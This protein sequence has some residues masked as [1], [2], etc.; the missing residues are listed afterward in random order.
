MALDGEVAAMITDT[1]V[2]EVMTLSLTTQSLTTYKTMI[3]PTS[4]MTPPITIRPISIKPI[5]ITTLITT[6]TTIITTMAEAEAMRIMA[7]MIMEGMEAPTTAEMRIMVA[8]I[9]MTAAQ[10]ITLVAEMM[11][12]RYYKKNFYPGDFNN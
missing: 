2:G 4:T 1:E 6:M 12:V 11:A 9:T 7:V 10:T 5:T 3:R 8:I